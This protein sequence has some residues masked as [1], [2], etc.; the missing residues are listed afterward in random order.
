MFRSAVFILVLAS[1]ASAQVGNVAPPTT[2][3]TTPKA[4]TDETCWATFKSM[5]DD[6]I[7]HRPSTPEFRTTCLA[8]AGR[9]YDA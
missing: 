6:C 1:L 3:P 5:C 9:W 7:A 4:E 2:T 8:A